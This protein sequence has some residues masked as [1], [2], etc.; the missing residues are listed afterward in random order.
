MNDDNSNS[1]S[2]STNANRNNDGGR[3]NGGRRNNTGRCGGRSGNHNKNNSNGKSKETGSISE[4]KDCILDC[5]SRKAMEANKEHMEHIHPH[6]GNT[7][8]KCADNVKCI[9][10]NLEDPDLKEPEMTSKEDAENRIECFQYQEEY[11]RYLDR[12]ERLKSSKKKPFNA[13]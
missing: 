4:M 10:K 3:G 8:G 13:I 2:N 12:K 11:K 6:I 9:M 5:S 7:F 1:S